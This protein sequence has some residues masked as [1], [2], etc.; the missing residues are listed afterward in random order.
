MRADR[1]VSEP[2]LYQRVCEFESK[3]V[4]VHACVCGCVCVH[5][6]ACLLKD[7]TNTVSSEQLF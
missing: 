4:S 5:V 7:P 3:C 2:R 1:P 6:G